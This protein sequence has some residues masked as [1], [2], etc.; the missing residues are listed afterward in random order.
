MSWASV[1]APR[2][3]LLG[4][5]RVLAAFREHLTT[6]VGGVSPDGAVRLDA[7][8]CGGSSEGA[9]FVE[10]DGKPLPN[11]GPKSATTIAAALRARGPVEDL[12]IA[13]AVSAWQA[14][15]RAT[16]ELSLEVMVHTVAESGLR[17]LGG[18][19]ATRLRLAAQP[20]ALRRGQQLRGPTPAPSSI[21]PSRSAIR[22]WP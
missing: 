22:T 18:G 17:G 21:A 13:G 10:I 4:G 16:S 2:Y 7:T 14:F 9:A 19:P 1:T 5:G 20:R 11:S 12:A 15:T 6:G 8:S 3:T